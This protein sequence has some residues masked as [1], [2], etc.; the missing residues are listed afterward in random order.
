[1]AKQKC[2]AKMTFA[3][4][5]GNWCTMGCDLIEGHFGKHKVMGRGG[6]EDNDFPYILEW[7][8]GFTLHLRVGSKRYR[9]SKEE[10]RRL[11]NENQRKND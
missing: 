7:G 5:N 3:D 9:L 2:N 10:L 8:A 4:D 1:M 11:R 6:N